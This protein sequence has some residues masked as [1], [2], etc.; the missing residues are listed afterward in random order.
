MSPFRITTLAENNTMLNYIRNAQ[1]KYYDLTQEAA[2]GLKVTKPSDDPSA[3][4]A[5]LNIDTQINQ[6]NG[7]LNSMSLA[8]NELNLLDDTL[9]SV[10]D[11]MQDASDLATQ[12]AN[13]T[14][15]EDSLD[16]IKVQIDQIIQSV[17]DLGN[18]DYNGTYIFSGTA[19]ATKTYSVTE[20]VDGNITAIT[21]NGTPSDEDYKRYVNISDG[22]SLAI[23][24]TGDQIFGEYDAAAGTSTGFLG[25][26]MTISNALATYDQTTVGTALD[27]LNTNLD[28]I[29]VTRTKFTS[30]TSRFEITQKSIDN[31]MS[32]LEAYQ[33]ELEDADLAEV[34]SDLSAQEL[35]LQATMSVTAELLGGTTLL[36]YI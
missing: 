31:T 20:D 33:S 23:N 21:Y 11:L 36:D 10:T 14:Y 7:Y 35:A 3:T 1:S 16:N 2:S 22:V 12:A 17:I 25:T 26:L 13:G 9:S 5:L 29:S 8:Q 34:L 28:T 30:V 6:M 24:T 4:K 32:Q 18:T 15:S 19:T 27:S